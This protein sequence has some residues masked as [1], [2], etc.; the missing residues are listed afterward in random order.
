VS[1]KTAAGRA[2]GLTP[3]DIYFLKSLRHSWWLRQFY[4]LPLARFEVP[5]LPPVDNRDRALAKRIIAFYEQSTRATNA[6]GQRS[7]L[8][9]RSLESAQGPLVA[10]LKRRDEE[11]LAELLHGFLRNQ[12]VRGIDPGDSYSGRNW[13]VHSLRLLDALVSLAEQR[14]VGTT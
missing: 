6:M 12:I 2:L 1:W 11:A 8:W 7:A 9:D 5:E 10:A 4:R 13:R 3:T 14:G